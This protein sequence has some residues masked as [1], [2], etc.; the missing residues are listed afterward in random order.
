M[1]NLRVCLLALLSHW[2]RHPLQFFSILVG[3]WLATTLWT[4]VQALNSQARSDY[5]RAS[6]VLAGPAQVQLIPRRGERIPQSAYIGLRRA[7]WPVS[8][9]L[10]GRLRFAGEPPISVQLLGIE[11]LTLPAGLQVA[12]QSSERLDLA[13]FLGEP[14]QAWI[15]PDTLQRLGLQAGD[16]AL[17]L[18]GQRLPPLQLQAQ[19]AP[20]VIVVDIGRAQALLH[21]PDQLSRLLLPGD[22]SAPALPPT[23]LDSL[24]LQPAADGDDLQRLTDSFHLNLTALGLLAFIVGLFI[25]HAAIGLALEQRRG[26]LRTLRACGVS[27][28]TLLGTLGLELGLLALLGGLAGVA[29]GY[30]LASLLLPDVA[31]S[32]RGLYGA[33][34][35]GQLSLSPLWWLTG[36]AIS[37]LGALLAGA[38]SLLRAARL[39]LLALAQPQAWR[40][41]QGIWLKRQ[42][43]VACAL[44]LVAVAVWRY[45]DSLLAGF[46]LLA[47]LL[48]AAA[49]LLPAL[50]DGSLALLARLCRGPLSEWFVADSRQQLPAL[51]LALMALLLALAASVGV[52][53]MTEGFRQTFSGWLDQRLAAELYLAPRDGDQANAVIGWLED[54]PGVEAILPQRRVELRLQGRPAQLQGIVDHPTYRQH[55]PLLEAQANAWDKLAAG[56]GVMLSEQL[57][58]HLRITLDATL[59]LPSETGV[60]QLPVVALYADYGNPKGHMLV[61]VDWLRQHWSQAPI[62]NIS[63]RVAPEQVASLKSALEQRFVLEGARLIDQQGLKSWS[64][65]IFERTF[66]ATAALNSLTLGVAGVALFISL[67]TLG[68]SRLSQLA[69]LWALGLSR[70]RLAWLSLAQTLMLSSL[71]VL[72][73][74]PLGLLLAWCLVAVV[75]VQA[76]GWRLPLHVFPVQLLQLALLG[77]LTSL[78]AAAGPLWQLARQSPAD[79]LR[80]F[81]DER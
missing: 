64:T 3:L 7:G 13:S 56:Q 70:P 48:L 63:L 9:L 14:G 19:L 42:A 44:L 15:A 77:L 12:G 53:S 67:L 35:A 81:A 16:V 71:T 51:S 65:Q 4:G 80:Q 23:L 66:A 47:S 5:A 79:L 62:S 18:D 32:L 61:N 1:D 60:Q 8:P 29:S 59:Q 57:A 37:L 17:T 26:L 52:G 27:L 39:P 58:R 72:L 33:E 10:E 54:Q 46:A 2:R 24:Q 69:P 75:N 78:L 74:M 38:S 68:Q 45:G 55:W 34:V 6:A 49:L 73:A 21:A 41:A 36:L 30:L 20:G 31:A 11:P 50:L 22:F 40:V 28:A 25:V 76:F 43:L